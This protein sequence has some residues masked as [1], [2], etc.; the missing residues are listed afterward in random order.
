[1][2]KLEP[3][4]VVALLLCLGAAAFRISTTS[5]PSSFCLFC[6]FPPKTELLKDA[7]NAG[8]AT[9]CAAHM[10][11]E[12]QTT[13]RRRLSLPCGCQ[14]EILAEAAAHSPRGRCLAASQPQ[15][16]KAI[17]AGKKTPQM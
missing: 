3:V 14:R 6:L 12:P 2:S 9:V 17:A 1:M 5:F 7:I 15:S 4:H 16:Q 11:K 8:S 10:F 13:R